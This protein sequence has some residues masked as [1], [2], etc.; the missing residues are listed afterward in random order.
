MKSTSNRIY[1]NYEGSRGVDSTRSLASAYSEI[2]LHK[3]KKL[4]Y[5]NVLVFVYLD[6]FKVKFD[7]DSG[8][9]WINLL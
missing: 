1:K 4:I 5:R 9:D 2:I 8:R 6:I 3:T 7:N